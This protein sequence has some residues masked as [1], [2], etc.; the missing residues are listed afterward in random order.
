MNDPAIGPP[1]PEGRVTGGVPRD[2]W[3]LWSGATVGGAIIGLIGTTFL[4]SGLLFI[5]PLASGSNLEALLYIFGVI[6]G[7]GIGGLQGRVLSSM[8]PRHVWRQWTAVSAAGVTAALI[9]IRLAW[10]L[11]ESMYSGLISRGSDNSLARPEEGS[12]TIALLAVSLVCGAVGGLV[13]GCV[14]WLVLR[15]YVERAAWWIPGSIAATAVAGV[16]TIL[17]LLAQSAVMPG[18]GLKGVYVFAIGVVCLPWPIIAGITGW[19]LVKLLQRAG[20]PDK[21]LWTQST[22]TK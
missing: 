4:V 14:Q 5:G 22:G 9:A 21:S 13:L 11:L 12:A 17:I 18:Q 10:P 6:T 7:L 3:W 15:R 16:S 1:S 8:L 19:L 20:G 2:L